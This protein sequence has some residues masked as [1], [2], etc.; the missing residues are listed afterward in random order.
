MQKRLKLCRQQLINAPEWQKP[1]RQTSWLPPKQHIF[2]GYLAKHYFTFLYHFVNARTR[3]SIIVLVHLA[4][5]VADKL[6]SMQ[7][8]GVCFIIQSW[9]PSV[10]KNAL[11]FQQ[12]QQATPPPISFTHFWL[13]DPAAAA[14]AD[15]ERFRFNGKRRRRRYMIRT[16]KAKRR[17]QT[18]YTAIG[19]SFHLLFF[20]L[21]WLNVQLVRYFHYYK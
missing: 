14:A 2:L 6:S 19:G 4:N 17:I 3:Y 15:V 16:N 13:I 9:S 12:Q 7:M 18:N 21:N 1:G 8:N 5:L 11:P 10:A 20:L